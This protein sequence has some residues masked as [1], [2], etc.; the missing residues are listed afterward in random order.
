[1]YHIFGLI[2]FDLFWGI[3]EY[4]SVN[5]GKEVKD[6]KKL[7][8]KINKFINWFPFTQH[9]IFTMTMIYDQ[10]DFDVRDYIEDSWES[11]LESAEDD[12]NPTGIVESLD[13]ETLKM[14]ED[15]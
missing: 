6:F 1:M 4:S 2:L 15:F 14:L 10:V 11:F 8:T 9:T 13:A 12:W 7:M 5:M 3:D